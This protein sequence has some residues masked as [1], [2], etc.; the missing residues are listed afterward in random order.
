MTRRLIAAARPLFARHGY[1]NTSIAAVC[2]RCGVSKGAFYHHFADKSELFE[3]VFEAEER[4][5][6][7][8]LTAAYARRRD[9][10]EGLV[11][12]MHA[13]LEAALDPG[14][15]QITLVDAPSALGWQRMREI[16]ARYEL[17]LLREGLEAT[18]ASGRLPRRDVDPLAHVLFGA[19]CQAVTYILEAEAKPEALRYVKRE[20]KEVVEALATAPR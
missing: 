9:P 5:L 2:E 19:M 1:A 7:G 20:L 18:V 17:A 10:V 16:Q 15:R 6:C 4:K 14:V 12:G 3:A 13:F 11:D 8:A